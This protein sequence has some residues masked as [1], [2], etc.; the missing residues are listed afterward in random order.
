MATFCAVFPLECIVLEQDSAG[1][2]V[3]LAVLFLVLLFSWCCLFMVTIAKLLRRG[4]SL[5]SEDG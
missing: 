3:D 5:S 1:G 2:P 4:W